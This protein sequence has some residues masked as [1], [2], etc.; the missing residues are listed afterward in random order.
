M[1]SLNFKTDDM[2]N[3]HKIFDLAQLTLNHH[4]HAED[5]QDDRRE[6][7]LR[8]MSTLVC[9]T[10]LASPT[11]RPRALS[12]YNAIGKSSNKFG[13]LVDDLTPP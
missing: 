11:W 8:F 5:D 1:V 13:K 9:S 3:K 6:A 10:C 2:R 4:F 7:M 12:F